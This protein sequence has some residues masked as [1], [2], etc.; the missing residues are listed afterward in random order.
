MS[1]CSNVRSQ[2][3]EYLDGAL[4]GIAMQELASHL[5]LCR[6]CSTEFE[7][8]RSA[9]QMLTG[10]GPAKAPADLALRL[11]VAIS[12]EK[13]NSPKQNLARW[14]VRWQNTVA[15]FL[16]QASAGFASAILLI[17]TVA[18][19]VG[20]VAAPE[21][22][23]AGDEPL[24]NASSPHFLYSSLAAT[25]SA[26]GD[27]DNPVVVEAYVNGNGRVYDY[28]IV[29]GPNDAHTRSQVE[30]Q[31]LFSVFEPAR[32]FGQPVRGL[33]I[34]SFSGVSVQG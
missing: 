19:M 29:S 16:L 8:W 21:P 11:R 26:I 22:A 30:N 24:G 6:K 9:Q 33:V 28:T 5:D 12:Q 10:L 27:R 17:G 3:S 25:P 15:P 2:F 1:K 13:M 23:S 34:L 14:Q 4:T 32:F 7:R 31:L 18:L 20:A